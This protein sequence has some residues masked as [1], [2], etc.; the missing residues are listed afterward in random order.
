MDAGLVR[1]VDVERTV[2]I[3]AAALF[4]ILG[5]RPVLELMDMSAEQSDD[6][7][8]WFAAVMDIIIHALRP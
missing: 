2:A 6:P 1:Q 4:L 7:T 5:A 8:A 3:T